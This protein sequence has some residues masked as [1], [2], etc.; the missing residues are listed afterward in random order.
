MLVDPR[1]HT[2]LGYPPHRAAEGGVVPCDD[3]AI[4]QRVSEL[5][6]LGEVVILVVGWSVYDS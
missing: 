3:G 1:R 5:G 6:S 2:D 4:H